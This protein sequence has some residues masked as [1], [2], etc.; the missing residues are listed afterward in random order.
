MAI[1][2]VRFSSTSSDSLSRLLSCQP[3]C[4]LKNETNSSVSFF[5]PQIGWH[6]SKRDSESLDIEENRTI[7]IAINIDFDF[8]F[9][10]WPVP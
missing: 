6:E 8:V 3:I 10:N 5:S 9:S 2:I 1:S 4:G 7:E